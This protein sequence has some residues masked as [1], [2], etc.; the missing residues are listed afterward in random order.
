MTKSS[1]NKLI[2]L[3]ASFCETKHD[4]I[5]V[6]SSPLPRIPG[7]PKRDKSIRQ[8]ISGLLKKELLEY[9]EEKDT[10]LIRPTKKAFGH[11]SKEYPLYNNFI[12]PWDHTFRLIAYNIS[13]KERKIRDSVRWI[14]KSYKLGVF[15]HSVFVSA[16]DIEKD[17]YQRLKTQKAKDALFIIPV[18]IEKTKIKTF[19]EYVWDTKTIEKECNLLE[20][21]LDIAI[22]TIKSRRGKVEAFRKLFIEY[23]RI[24]IKDPGLPFELTGGVSGHIKIRKLFKKLQRLL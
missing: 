24:M 11:L 19:T 20:K 3:I 22:K 9:K 2:F 21:E 7:F 8:G 1:E 12:S 23:K 13:E 10:V 6:F 17:L 14:L 4:W 5:D 15:Q 16:Y 18:S